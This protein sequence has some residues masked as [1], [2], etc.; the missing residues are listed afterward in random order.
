MTGRLAIDFGTSNTVLAVWDETRQEGIPLHIPEFGRYSRQ[1]DE[2]VSTI[3]S[4]IHYQADGRRWIGAQVMDRNLYNSRRT[5][6]WMKR[7]ISSRSPIRIR[8][9]DREITPYQAGS[10][11]LSTIL[12]FAQQ[13]LNVE[14]QEIAL[15]V[16]VEAFEHYENWLTSVLENA[17]FTR[18]RLIDEPSAAAL[19]YG[20]H[21]QPGNVYMVFDFGG[22]TLNTSVVFM[23]AEEKAIT[24]KRCRVLGK[25]GKSIGGS[26]IDQWV[27][28]EI[29]RRAKRSDA[30]DDIRAIS[31][32]LLVEA[33]RVKQCLSFDERVSLHCELPNGEAAIQTDFSRQ[34]FEDIL[35][36]HHLYED[37]G[38]AIR[39]ALNSAR[40][41]GY[42]ENSIQAVLMVGGSSQIPSVQRVVRQYFGKERVWYNRPLDAIARG[43]AAFVAGVDLFDHIQ[44]DYAIR[45]IDPARGDYDYRI[46]VRQGTPYPTPEPIARLSIKASYHGQQQLGLAIFEM[47]GSEP[48]P[49][50]NN[51][52]GMEIIFDP[53]G[54]AR[55]VQITHEEN[56]QRHQFWMNEHTPTFLNATAPVVAGEPQFDVEFRVDAN[57]RL[58]LTARNLRTG[59]ITHDMTPVV[60][61]V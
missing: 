5:M 18:F 58:V 3:P 15:S 28:T 59:Q 4:V 60:Q 11:F 14:G 20:A 12:I 13:E 53:S 56:R 19:G 61:L 47:S 26:S 34:Q 37:I 27:F 16:P 39:A 17:N 9:D 46:L 6:R 43:G 38:Q 49:G 42:D 35:D 48:Q 52:R 21:V 7:Y 41:R 36:A 51:G 45:Y 40:E 8:V 57:K 1:L 55:I 50:D 30:D 54:A 22:G 25:S 29:L 33:E 10:D 23:E 32:T 24:G 2:E 31:N 44:H